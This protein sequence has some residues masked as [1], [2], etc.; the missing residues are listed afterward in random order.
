MK[1][2]THRGR[3]TS[4]G[5]W[6]CK[7]EVFKRYSLEENIGRSRCRLQTKRPRRLQGGGRAVSQSTKLLWSFAHA[8]QTICFFSK[9]ELFLSRITGR[10]RCK[11][12]IVARRAAAL[13]APQS[14]V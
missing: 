12:P 3:G 9:K 5:L 10:D 7:K 2:L 1:A 8:S 11:L 14:L 13:N 4:R 6:A